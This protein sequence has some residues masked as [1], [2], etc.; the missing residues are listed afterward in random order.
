MATWLPDGVVD[1]RWFVGDPNRELR[2]SKFL[3]SKAMSQLPPYILA[4]PRV[5]MDMNESSLNTL[6]TGEE[7][8]LEGNS[9]RYSSPQLSQSET[10]LLDEDEVKNLL[11]T[12]RRAGEAQ[13]KRSAEVIRLPLV[14]SWLFSTI[15]ARFVRKSLRATA[16]KVFERP[17]KRYIKTILIDMSLRLAFELLS[18]KREEG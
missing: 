1:P 11:S 3:G 5:R 18:P 13:D 8:S 9:G 7:K 10:R 14:F 4:S 2:K 15:R 17:L 6:K 16:T 12:Y